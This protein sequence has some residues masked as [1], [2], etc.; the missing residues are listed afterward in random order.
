MLLAEGKQVSA[1]LLGCGSSL[2]MEFSRRDLPQSLPREPILRLMSKAPRCRHRAG[3]PKAAPVGKELQK[4]ARLGR[5][6]GGD[7]QKAFSN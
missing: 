6:G 7:I 3:M 5:G 2:R 4:M 1:E